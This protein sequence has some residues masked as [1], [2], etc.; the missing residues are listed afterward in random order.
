MKGHPL[1]EAVLFLLCW[2]C[3]LWPLRELTRPVTASSATPVETQDEART[4][5]WITLKSSAGL[6][7][8][9]LKQG[10]EAVLEEQLKESTT[11]EREVELAWTSDHRLELRIDAT[12]HEAGTKALEIIIEPDGLPARSVTLW[13]DATELQ[14]VQVFSW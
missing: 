3:L 12:W 9:T 8:V 7:A 14:D 11:C 10:A 4:A 2:A 5:S 1:I 13:T 6:S